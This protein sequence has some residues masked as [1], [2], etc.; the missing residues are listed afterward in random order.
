[1]ITFIIGFFLGIVF[2]KLMDYLWKWAE[3][4]ISN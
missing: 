4:D 1:M 3:K 2:K